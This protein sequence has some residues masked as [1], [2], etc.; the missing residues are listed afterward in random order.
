MITSILNAY[1]D[2][3]VFDTVMRDLQGIADSRPDIKDDALISR[4]N[5]GT[6]TRTSELSSSLRRLSSF[7]YE[8]Y[9]NLPD[10]VLRLLTSAAGDEK[11]HHV[12]EGAIRDADVLQAQ[13][14]FPAFEII[15]KSGIPKQHS[16]EIWHAAWTHLEGPV[17]SIR[18]KTAKT[19][20]Y[21]PVG[22]E[23]Q[24][25]ME[26]CLQQ[27]PWPSQNALH[28]R[29][30]YL[31]FLFAR[32]EKDA[33]EP[34]HRIFTQ[35]VDCFQDMIVLNRCPI[36][37]SSHTTL[38]ADILSAM[39]SQGLAL[40]RSLDGVI[41]S[42]TS[43]SIYGTS[44]EVFSMTHWESFKMYLY[45]ESPR[46]PEFTLEDTA[47]SRCRLLADNLG[48]Q[49]GQERSTMI[50]VSQSIFMDHG[51]RGT[52][53]DPEHSNHIL[54]QTGRFLGHWSA[55][56][57]ELDLFTERVECW[58]RA[59]RLAQ[60]DDVDVSA[61]QAAVDSLSQYLHITRNQPTEKKIIPKATKLYLILYD[62][63]LDDDEDV[64][65]TAAA[66]ASELLISTTSK[67]ENDA[68]MSMPLMVPAARSSLLKFLKCHYH[69]APHL[70]TEAAQRLVAGHLSPYAPPKSTFPSPRALLHE[71]KQDD[72]A[73]FVEEKQN[74]Y[75][76]EAQEAGVWQE[77]MLSMH[78][79]A[80]DHDMLA[81]LGKWSA[82]GLDALIEVAE[83]EEDGPLGWTSKPDVFTFGTR[84]LLA[85][86]ALLRLSEGEELGVDADGLLARLRRL[87]E[88]GVRSLL[89]AAWMRIIRESLEEWNPS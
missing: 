18:E 46:K 16:T 28:G 7:V 34:I 43:P 19:L 6:N 39:T 15:E 20:S 11:S 69:S 4:L 87:E 8:K 51:N 49:D 89:R 1:P 37:R 59:L 3:E 85:A 52:P 58:A 84:V 82:E 86:Q 21:L 81:E 77:V 17:W 22:E 27:R 75:I 74:L 42:C 66:A 53:T 23:I 57:E 61:R 14:V 78:R 88:A 60:N 56:A 63:L 41:D 45:Q 35:V 36:T 26:R 50:D 72:T 2:G 65:N 13:H 25:E 80:I 64:R 40:G 67:D 24:R 5:D 83:N 79:S 47:K 48:K 10:I 62:F 71:L 38:V 73:L 29:H 9:Q 44:S 70:W 33:I 55:T 31:R 54:R 76:D 32:M 68:E 30:L 12:P